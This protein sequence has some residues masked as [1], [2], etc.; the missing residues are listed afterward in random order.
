MR[1]TRLRVFLEE[2]D[3][4]F[5]GLDWD[6]RYVYANARAVSLTGKSQAELL[7]HRPWEV[8]PELVGT[9]LDRA[10][11]EA[12]ELGR[13]SVIEYRSV[14]GGTGSRRA[15]IPRPLV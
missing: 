8:H 15:S 2:I 14:I 10:Y 6:Y 9:P 5:L 11:H 3:E 1:E 12:M 7:G 4:S 13:P